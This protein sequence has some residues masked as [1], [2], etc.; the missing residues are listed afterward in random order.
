ME[1]L[2][3]TVNLLAVLECLDSNTAFG[4]SHNWI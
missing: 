3:N 1:A 2:K 4:I